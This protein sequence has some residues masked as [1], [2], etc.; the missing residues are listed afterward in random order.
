MRRQR[1]RHS[2]APCADAAALGATR[3]ARRHRARRPACQSARE[4][5]ALTRRRAG[6][7]ALH[8]DISQKQRE[9][10]LRHF[11]DGKFVALVAT[12][13][14]ARGLDISDVDL[15]RACAPSGGSLASCL[16]CCARQSLGSTRTA[17]TLC[18]G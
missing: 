11:R 8:G 16:G 17:V 2:Q 4:L 9:T 12:D 10:V 18:G 5:P 15:V 1:L 14:A 3:A 13:V 7:Q 6:R